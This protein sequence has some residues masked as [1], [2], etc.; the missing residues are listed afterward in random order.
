[1]ATYPLQFTAQAPARE[2]LKIN[3]RQAAMESPH[4]YAMQVVHTAS[5]WTLDFTWPRMTVAEAQVCQAWLDSLRGQVGTFRYTPRARTRNA[6][7]GRSLAQAAYAYGNTVGLSGWSGNA[8]GGVA[9]GQFFQLGDQ[10]LRVTAVP[11]NA[12]AN[13]QLLVEFEPMLRANYAQGATVNFTNPSGLFRLASPD[14]PS[15]D[16]DVDGHPAFPSVIAK[17][18]I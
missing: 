1:M 10:L 16:T 8:A 6:L 11:A 15:F 2:Q 12:D 9:V 13:G 4:T 18:A 17:E 3:N 14:T 5:Q 7:T